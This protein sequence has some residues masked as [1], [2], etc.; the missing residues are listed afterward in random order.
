MK[1]LDSIELLNL[2]LRLLKSGQRDQVPVSKLA[3]VQLLVLRCRKRVADVPMAPTICDD[4]VMGI[5]VVRNNQTIQ[6]V[7]QDIRDTLIQ[8]LQDCL[9]QVCAAAWSYYC[10]TDV[11]ISDETIPLL[12]TIVA[13]HFNK[14]A[15]T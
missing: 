12:R 13:Y 1:Y 4:V 11:P 15:L 2:A 7:P 10:D 9:A 6:F 5:S 3:E 14:G 8:G